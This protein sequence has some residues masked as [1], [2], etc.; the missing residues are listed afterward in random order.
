MT[1]DVAL[2]RRRHERRQ[3]VGDPRRPEDPPDAGSLCLGIRR[4]PLP[5]AQGDLA[6]VSRE[7]GHRRTDPRVGDELD[8]ARHERDPLLVIGRA[9]RIARLAEAGQVAD[10]RDRSDAVVATLETPR[11]DRGVVHRAVEREVHLHVP[12]QAIDDRTVPADAQVGSE[13][14]GRGVRDDIPVAGWCLRARAVGP[15][16]RDRPVEVAL[17]DDLRGVRAGRRRIQRMT[18][19]VVRPERVRADRTR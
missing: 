17:P 15:E 19:P 12:L 9:R 2:E 13:L 16:L 18:V 8:E 10:H 6:L 4:V 1:R 11:G 14:V 7:P 3:L 5:R